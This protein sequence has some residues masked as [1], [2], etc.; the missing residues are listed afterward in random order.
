MIIFA[1]GL[2]DSKIILPEND[3]AVSKEDFRKNIEKLHEKSIKFSEKAVFVGLTP[4]DE[5]KTN[6]IPKGDKAYRNESINEYD[7]L[8]R[9]FCNE[10]RII[11][12]DVLQDFLNKD[13]KTLLFDGL[14]PNDKVHELLFEK[15]R[16][17]LQQFL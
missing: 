2:N 12:V 10:K 7:S 3:F 13:Y 9:E 14:H 16:E 4:V 11:F 1:I 5:A 15:I 6:P 17:S 8:L